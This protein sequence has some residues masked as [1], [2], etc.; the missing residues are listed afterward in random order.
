MVVV[1]REFV[2]RDGP[3]EITNPKV[4]TNTVVGMVL[5]IL[6]VCSVCFFTLILS[7]QILACPCKN[8][9]KNA[10]RVRRRAPPR[11]IVI[12]TLN[13]PP[14][15]TRSFRNCFGL[16]KSK[17]KRHSFLKNP[18]STPSTPVKDATPDTRTGGKSG[19]R[20]F[21]LRRGAP[22]E[23]QNV[24][25]PEST[26]AP[27]QRPTLRERR[28]LRSLY[29]NTSLPSPRKR[30]PG[31]P[32]PISPALKRMG[33]VFLFSDSDPPETPIPT[34]TSSNFLSPRTPPSRSH[35]HYKQMDDSLYSDWANEETYPSPSPSR[36][37]KFPK[38]A[39]ISPW[40]PNEGEFP[41][42][43]YYPHS[44]GLASP[45]LGGEP[46]TP[47]PLYPPPPAYLPEL[48]R[49]GSE[50]S[51]GSAPTTPTRP[52]RSGTATPRGSPCTTP[53]QISNSRATSSRGMGPGSE[54]R[55]PDAPPVSPIVSTLR[56]QIEQDIGSWESRQLREAL[57]STVT[58]DP[59][60]FVIAD[61]SEDGHSILSDLETLSVHTDDSLSREPLKL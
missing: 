57:A 1:P 36:G 4:A 11:D 42:Y 45:F 31:T 47:P 61:D 46:H 41:Y 56:E 2:P 9:R 43:P 23:T 29:L 32:S 13:P 10:R 37:T 48:P 18:F 38:D 25:Q 51:G 17:P 55:V 60:V 49:R 33:R 59:G 27:N 28:A 14:K 3:P 50:A 7:Y 20:S 16:V 35:R 39:F 19:L 8:R 40:S 53:K 30:Y 58:V 44:P 5:A 6:L 22:D 21:F 12:T 24:T 54:E 15:P 34:P 52:T 26:S